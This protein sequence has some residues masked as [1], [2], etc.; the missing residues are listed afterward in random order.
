[1]KKILA[2]S[3]SLSSDSINHKLT[4]YA[5]D[6]LSEADVS[7]IRL[8]GHVAPF[9]SKGEE[10]ANGIPAGINELRKLFDAADGFIISIPEYNGSLPAG[11]KNTMDWLSR[12]EGKIFQEKPVVLMATSPGGRGGATVLAHLKTVLPFWGADV[13]G[14]FSLPQFQKNF[15][16]GKLE[17]EF[18]TELQK[19]IAILTEKLKSD[20]A[21]K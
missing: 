14:S 13:V 15:V 2:F 17:S 9:Y 4:E 21:T 12:M 7:V 18:D 6:K 8:S 1:M 10:D 16:D 5:A 11:F 19:T 3:G 20:I